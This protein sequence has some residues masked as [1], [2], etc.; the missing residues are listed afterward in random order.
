MNYL[1]AEACQNTFVLFDCLNLT[2]LGEAFFLNALAGLKKEGR[3]DAL[4]LFN[5]QVKDETFTAHLVVL[6]LDGQLAEF[7]GNGARVCAAYLY[8]RYPFFKMMYLKTHRSTYP[9]SCCAQE[10]YSVTLPSAS[11]E[12]N[13]KFISNPAL[14]NSEFKYVETGEPHLL[15]QK[16]MGDEQLLV[17]G[18][19][20]NQQTDLFPLGI[21]VNAWSILEEGKIFVKTYERGV[22]RLTRSCGTG[23]VA[24][25][26]LYRNRG[27]VQVVNPGG[28]LKVIFK[29][30]EVEL[31]G[32]AQVTL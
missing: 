26:A 3:D 1:L 5:G 14:I 19:K 31:Y 4:I 2:H 9:L 25:A 15:V 23:S 18:R 13:P 8:K 17:L 20:L 21:N 6:G 10:M 30:K 28:C 27:D 32:S 12:W 16:I 11:F 22:Q 29:E 24:C 7:C